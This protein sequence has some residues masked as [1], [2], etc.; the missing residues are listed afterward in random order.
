[1]TTSMYCLYV[2]MYVC[3][4]LHTYIPVC[5]YLFLCTY[6]YVCINVYINVC[7][8]ECLYITHAFLKGINLSYCENIKIKLSIKIPLFCI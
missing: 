5:T 2:C 3:V 8:R 6:M 7:K 1:M 4:C